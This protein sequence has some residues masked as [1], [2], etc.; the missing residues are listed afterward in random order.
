MAK[1]PKLIIGS[2]SVSEGA[3][4]FLTS[5]VYSKDEPSVD[6]P[7]TA[8]VEAFRFAFALGY[9]MNLKKKAVGVT[10][11]VAP[12]QFVVTE[13]QDILENDIDKNYSSL[14]ALVSGYAEAGAEIML[15]TKQNGKNVLS[16]I[17]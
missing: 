2:V 9:S 11:T 5:L 4:N 15:E 16:L 12:R 13:Y 7:F 10:K 8:I 1:K 17:E 3:H 14:G 6:A